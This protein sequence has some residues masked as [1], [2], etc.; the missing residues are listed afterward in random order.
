MNLASNQVLL[1]PV[2]WVLTFDNTQRAGGN[3][4]VMHCKTSVLGGET[5][6]MKN[7]ERKKH[8]SYHESYLPK[9]GT[10]THFSALLTPPSC[11]SLLFPLSFLLS[12]VSSSS[13]SSSSSLFSS[14]S[15]FSLSL[16]V[17]ETEFHARWGQGRKRRGVYETPAMCR[18]P[19]WQHLHVL[20]H[21]TILT[22]TGQSS[23]PPW[24]LS[25]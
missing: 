22:A 9:R 17:N 2:V 1:C 19:C 23:S 8:E 5:L 6:V 10:Q 16:S 14:Y 18:S 21:R 15:P 13:S 7:K 12:S 25:S 3:A 11:P 24:T 4:E 20:F